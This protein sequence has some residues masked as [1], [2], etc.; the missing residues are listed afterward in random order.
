MFWLGRP[1]VWSLA[2]LRRLC[3]CEGEGAFGLGLR[4]FLVQ[5][6]DLW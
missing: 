6:L 5:L 3:I 1:L 2:V 4:S